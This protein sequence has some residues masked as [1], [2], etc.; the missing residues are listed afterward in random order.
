MAVEQMKNSL[1]ITS[2]VCLCFQSDSYMLNDTQLST[3]PLEEFA[4]ERETRFQEPPAAGPGR[5][6][7]G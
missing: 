3:I 6:D 4:V 2:F 5:Q 7:Q 1:S